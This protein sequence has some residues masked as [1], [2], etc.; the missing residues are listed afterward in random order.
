MKSFLA[1][2]FRKI[3]SYLGERFHNSVKWLNDELFLWLPKALKGL[4]FAGLS[5]LVISTFYDSFESG[6]EKFGFFARLFQIDDVFDIINNAFSPYLTNYITTDFI[7]MCNAFG[8]ISAI[9]EVLNAVGWSLMVY[10]FIFIVRIIFSSLSSAL[11][12]IPKP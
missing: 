6:L 2:I 4:G 1:K 3:S 7:G 5:A 12:F 10:L 9:N 11:L 8:I